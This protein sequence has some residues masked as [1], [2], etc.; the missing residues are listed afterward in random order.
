MIDTYNLTYILLRL[1]KHKIGKTKLIFINIRKQFL[2]KRLC[3]KHSWMEDFWYTLVD[4]YILIHKYR[5][6]K[7][8]LQNII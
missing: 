2:N 5:D 6:Y 4:V 8:D 1:Q 3:I 7:Q